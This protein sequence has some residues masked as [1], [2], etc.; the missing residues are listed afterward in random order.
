MSDYVEL[1]CHTN[2][3]LL[4]GA[5]RPEDLLDRAQELG[6]DRLAVTDHDGLYGAVRFWHAAGERGI[7]P[8]VGAELTLDGGYHVTLLAR[9]DSG[10]SNLCRLISQAQLAHAK[11]ESS[12]AFDVLAQHSE[13]LICLSGCDKGEIAAK[14]GAAHH[15]GALLAARRYANLFGPES[16]YAE[17]QRHLLPGD[18]RLVKGL[19][20][21]AEH[22]ELRCVATNNV[23]YA[24]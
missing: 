14:L 23:H 11:G 22:L 15:E 12:L 16:F 4:D 19:V 7:K 10:Y 13:G 2:Y 3:S 6:L 8:I 1:H 20:E 9:D 21:L 24:R 5:S 18:K 17:L